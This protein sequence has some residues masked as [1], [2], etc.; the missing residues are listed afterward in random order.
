M[1]P[2]A[3]P[4]MGALAACTPAQPPPPPPLKL[5][6]ALGFEALSARIVAQTRPA[7]KERGEP[8]RYYNAP[9]GQSSYMVT[10]PGAPGHPAILKQQATPAGVTN[11]GC[12]YG[13]EK[14]YAE[15]VA[16]LEALAR[17]RAK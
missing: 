8:F 11:S 6:C 3:L 17:A 9:G 7:V 4:L 5:D 13:D 2:W 1:R 15:L 14:G 10:E 16:Y 12:A